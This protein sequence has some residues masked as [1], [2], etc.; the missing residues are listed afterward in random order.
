MRGSI[1]YQTGKLAATLYAPNLSKKTQRET[2]FVANAKTLGA[3][4]PVWNELGKYIFSKYGVR[5]FQKI[6]DEHVY[7]YLKQKF[8]QNLSSQRAELIVSAIGKL[9][10]ALKE[11]GELFE[12]SNTKYDFSKRIE[13]LH[14][15]KKAGLLRKAGKESGFTRAYSDPLGLIKTIENPLFR[16]AARIQFEG[17]AR[18]EAVVRI[19]SKMPI[20][21]RKLKENH[22]HEKIEVLEWNDEHVVV[23][24]LQGI[25]QDE[26]TLKEKGHILTIEKGGKPGIVQV[27]KEV[28]FALEKHILMHG[29]F[30]VEYKKYTESLKKAALKTAQKYQGS[31]GLRWNF[32]Q[33]RV[34]ELQAHG[35]SKGMANQVVS[36]EMKH[37]RVDITDHYL[38]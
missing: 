34:L 20:K 31:H 26:W 12:N 2:G 18:A 9:E 29:R 38:G 4:R 25:H 5:D 22:L 35:L 17:G 10:F 3:Y 15:A 23:S 13:M 37:E 27:S 33:N 19:D 36:W 14:H 30:Q 11:A 28:Y 1:Y 16:L 8:S 32:A 21:E 7:A 6:E 24:Q